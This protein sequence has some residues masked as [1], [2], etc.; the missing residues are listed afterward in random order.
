MASQEST[1]LRGPQ[2]RQGPPR[3]G[4]PAGC[5]V[6]PVPWPGF[7]RP[8]RAE[9]S[10][11]CLR[12]ETPGWP[13]SSGCSVLSSGCSVL[14]SPVFKSSS[15]D[16]PLSYWYFPYSVICPLTVS[17]APRALESHTELSDPSLGEEGPLQS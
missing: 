3:P 7:P 8:G 16:S 4:Q 13:A 17:V 10:H 6:L 15:D 2:G 9:P 12:A 5:H 1:P 11:T 14:S